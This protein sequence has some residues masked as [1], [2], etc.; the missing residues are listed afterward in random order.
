MNLKRITALF[1]VLAL[2]LCAC[3]KAP[4]T[5]EQILEKMN[6]ALA[7]NPCTRQEMTM[8]VDMTM[9]AG[10]DGSF[11]MSIASSN[12]M[13]VCLEPLSALNVVTS[14]VTAE[15][16]TNTSS[17]ESYTRL[18]DGEMTSYICNGGIWVKGTS[19]LTEQDLRGLRVSTDL[20]GAALDET[21][22]EWNGKSAICLTARMDGESL[23]QV[24]A[25]S[26]G[27]LGVGEAADYSALACDTR[28]YLDAQTYL[29]LAEEMTIIGMDTLL[30]AAFE[31]T[32]VGVTISSCTAATV[33]DSYEPQAE[34]TLPEGAAE[35]AA[36]WERLLAG[37]CDN[38][39]GTYTIREGTALI[40]VATPE[41]FTLE[42]KDYDHVRFTRDDHRTVTYEMWYLTGDA[43][44]YFA[45]MVDS[46]ENRYSTNGGQV[47]RQQMTGS[48]DTLPFT[49]E[50]MGVIWGSGREDAY[51]Y[52]W[53][54]LTN[55]ENGVY[56]LLVEITD[57]YSDIFGN[58]KSAD[59][60]AEEFQ[61]YLNGAACSPFNP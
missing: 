38:G 29:P 23:K 52:A 24:V 57:G 37:E 18:E 15:G 31:G 36:A 7:E 3:G 48:S 41:G 25:D 56:C 20:S 8:E 51:M 50:I 60:T 43:D 58:S 34:I 59:I 12:T 9:D 46:D 4:E 30:S 14:T 27:A 2:M 6:A 47:Q 40:D 39:D 54:T 1:L 26:I 49:C 22:T 53:T 61:T 32:G 35:S 21:V 16:A 13:T 11:A 28:V 44:T 33:F 5:P 17:V 10:A 45:S 42:E 19:E 55:D